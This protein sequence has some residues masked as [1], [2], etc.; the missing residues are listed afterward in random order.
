MINRSEKNVINSALWAAYGDALGFI[1]ELA[2]NNILK[3]RTSNNYVSELSE[4]K[5]KVGGKFG[6][7]V[8]LPK[9]AYSDDTQLRLATSRSIMGNGH[10]SLHSFSKIEL[11]V[12]QSYALGAGIGSKVAVNALSKPNVAWY[13]NFYSSKNVHY[14]Q[15]GGNGAAIRIQPHV[16]S[17]KKLDDPDL[18]LPDV[19][20]NSL[21]THGNARAIAG[22]VFHALSLAYSLFYKKLP[23]FDE[24][25]LFNQWTLEIPRILSEDDNLNTIWVA[26]YENNAEL[27]LIHEYQKVYE[28]IEELIDKAKKWYELDDKTYKNLAEILDLYNPKTRGAG[29]VTAVA[30]SVSCFLLQKVTESELIKL[31]ANELHTDTDSI[32]TMAGAV[33]GA[34]SDNEPNEEV[35]DQ[36]YIIQEAKRLYK[37]SQEIET[38]SFEYPN[39]LS[40]K[41]PSSN[42]DFLTVS[43]KGFTLYPFGILEKVN[44]EIY[45]P[46]NKKYCYEWFSSNLGQSFLIKRRFEDEMKDFVNADSFSEMFLENS[47]SI[48]RTEI[49]VKDSRKE[50]QP[51]EIDLDKIT[52]EIIK[53]QFDAKKLGQA[54]LDISESN[55]GINGVV[56]FSSI[57]S[58]AYISRKNKK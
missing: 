2:D 1:T 14:L 19:I 51:R 22:S 44:G 58:K 30:A 43:N 54:I 28:E 31:I 46:K 20:K 29:S 12:W 16:W 34:V 17:A 40:W 4:W 8:T 57:I 53:E 35:Q 15:S 32:A 39:K 11:P 10:F 27:P 50:K 6:V 25:R 18:F 7:T 55:L 3:S 38:E 48:K 41:N 9:G 37:I 33:L 42:L 13:N 5:R 49:N 26:Q 24:L 52:S 36:K 23:H 45:S 56:A 21:T 47:N